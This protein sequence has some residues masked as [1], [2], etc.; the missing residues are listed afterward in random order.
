MEKVYRDQITSYVDALTMRLKVV[1]V[2][3]PGVRD[4]LN[5][6][7]TTEFTDAVKRFWTVAQ[8]LAHAAGINGVTPPLPPDHKKE[9]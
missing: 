2:T 1:K 5:M 3:I 9:E 4:N 6:A 7:R 8:D